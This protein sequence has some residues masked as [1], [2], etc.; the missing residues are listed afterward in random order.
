MTA[1]REQARVLLDEFLYFTKRTEGAYLVSPDTTP[2]G[3]VY[4]YPMEL[5]DQDLLIARFMD[6]YTARPTWITQH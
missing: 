3:D 4:P 5:A 6:H 1:D 2:E